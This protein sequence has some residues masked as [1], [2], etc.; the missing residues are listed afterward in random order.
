MH[1]Q[2][3]FLSLAVRASPQNHDG[4]MP[5]VPLTPNHAVPGFRTLQVHVAV[6]GG[7]PATHGSS[8][9]V[10]E[11]A[12]VL[13]PATAEPVVAAG[14]TPVTQENGVPALPCG[15]TS[16][17]T[18]VTAIALTPQAEAYIDEEIEDRVGEAIADLC[19]ETIDEVMD[20]KIEEQV[21]EALSEYTDEVANLESRIDNLEAS[22]VDD[23]AFEDLRLDVLTLTA[24]VDQLHALREVV[25]MLTATCEALTARVAQL[26]HAAGGTPCDGDAA[27]Q[28]AE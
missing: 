8:N 14:A 25:A 15:P 10:V 11:H 22:G 9:A 20:D 26:E 6:Q 19:D 28:G 4:E 18:V 1:S 16:E 23:E 27:M 7:A 21:R 13:S 17:P 12:P 2:G 5:S 3:V 24:R